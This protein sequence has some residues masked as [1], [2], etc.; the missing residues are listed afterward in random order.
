MNE[1]AKQSYN[2][3]CDHITKLNDKYNKNNDEW[4]KR[5]FKCDTI[6]DNELKNIKFLKSMYI[7]NKDCIY[8]STEPDELEWTANFIDNKNLLKF[9]NNNFNNNFNNN[10]N[11]NNF[12]NNNDDNND[13]YNDA[14]ALFN[15]NTRK[16]ILT[17][18]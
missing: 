2:I 10:N 7:T 15:E 6:Q 8:K 12:N 3:S 17:R 9:V 13:N 4:Y 14:L 11:N 18:Y 5:Q 1:L 16:K